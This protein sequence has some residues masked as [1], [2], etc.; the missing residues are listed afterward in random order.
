MNVALLNRQHQEIGAVMSKIE[1]MLEQQNLEEKAFDI[2][3]NIGLLS[4]KLVTHLDAEDKF[5][6]PKLISDQNEKTSATSQKFMQEMGGLVDVFVNYKK[7]YMI[8]GNIKKQPEK[9]IIDTRS[10]FSAVKKRVMAE[11][12]ELYPLIG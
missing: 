11:E 12:N 5:L 6:Y 8:A 7:E 1:N 9:F 10:V 3:L 4:G 2:S